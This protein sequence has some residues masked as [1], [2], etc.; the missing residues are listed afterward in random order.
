MPKVSSQMLRKADEIA[1]NVNI[2]NHQISQQWMQ[3]ML[4]Q[5]KVE[6]S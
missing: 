3:F 5:N 6:T 1:E 2:A 4:K